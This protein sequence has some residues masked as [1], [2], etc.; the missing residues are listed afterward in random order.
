MKSNSDTKTNQGN[1]THNVSDEEVARFAALADKWWDPNGPFRPLHKINPVRLE[2]IRTQL[3][4]HF[5]LKADSMSPL[6]KLSL[7]DIGC[8]GGL[9]SE[10]LAKIGAKVTAIDAAEK[11]IHAA[12]NHAN[13]FG[14]NI[15]YKNVST[16]ALIAN[17]HK[18]DVVLALEVVE[19][20]LD[21]PSFIKSCSLLT[22]SGG[23]VFF[24]TLN[25]TPASWALGIVAA[26][27][28]LGWLPRGTHTWEKFVKPSELVS[29]M[30]KESLQPIDLSGLSYNIL[31]KNWQKS[32][33]LSVNYMATATSVIEI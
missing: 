3:C 32:N 27:Y 5:K 1:N 21:L 7:L 2:Y 23:I 16:E 26:E 30:K 19:H 9:I 18:F 11:N 31:N 15:N 4:Q 8:G 25:R 28:I 22:N 14:I 12:Q 13:R 17:E 6:S 10:P 33:N 24:S 20:V 29:L